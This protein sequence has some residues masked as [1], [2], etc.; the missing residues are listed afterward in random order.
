MMITSRSFTRHQYDIMYAIRK[1]SPDGGFVDTKGLLEEMA[2][3]GKPVSRKA[4]PWSLKPLE[5]AGMIR[6][7]YETRNG[8]RRA[9][10]NLTPMAYLY[11]GSDTD[12]VILEM[13]KDEDSV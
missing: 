8:R 2:R 6:R 12:I 3:I 11:L 4:I 7:T 1:G 9:C 10:F 5:E 13:L